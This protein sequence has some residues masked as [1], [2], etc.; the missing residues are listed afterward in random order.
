[1]IL[2]TA[3]VTVLIHVLLLL[4]VIE[5]VLLKYDQGHDGA[6]VFE[7]YEKALHGLLEAYRAPWNVEA[8][9]MPIQDTTA[10]MQVSPMQNFR[11]TLLVCTMPSQNR[12]TSALHHVHPLT[13]TLT[14]A[15]YLMILIIIN[16]RLNQG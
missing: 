10:L 13:M 11:L 12:L 3:K 5:G 8:L 9:Q 6:V 14:D 16:M 4:Q 1:M 2:R 7:D 15:M